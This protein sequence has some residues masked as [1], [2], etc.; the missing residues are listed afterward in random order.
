MDADYDEVFFLPFGLNQKLNEL[1]VLKDNYSLGSLKII[2]K[3][4]RNVSFYEA[5]PVDL[6]I[7]K[8]QP[9]VLYFATF[10]SAESG[11]FDPEHICKG[12]SDI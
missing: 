8:V 3:C 9:L 6:L 7:L 2:Y 11:L 5:R 4:Q 12:A 10:G 1:K